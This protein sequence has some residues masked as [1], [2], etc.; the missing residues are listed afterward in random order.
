[1]NRGGW[2]NVGKV[3][4]I[5]IIVSIFVALRSETLGVNSWGMK[6]SIFP[7]HSGCC[8]HGEFYFSSPFGG[9]NAVLFPHKNQLLAYAPLDICDWINFTSYF[10]PTTN[11]TNLELD[12]K[13]PKIQCE[14]SG[15]FGRW[16]K[17]LDRFLLGFT[18]D[19]KLR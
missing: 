19:L 11:D 5:I 9:C 2:F 8:F 6:S 10:N 7:Y 4:F 3:F 14:K 13:R 16:M 15:F 12:S 1:M 17:H 18:D